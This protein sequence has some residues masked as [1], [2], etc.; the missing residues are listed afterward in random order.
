MRKSLNRQENK[1]AVAATGVRVDMYP[2]G[3]MESRAAARAM[4]KQRMELSQDDEDALLIYGTACMLSGLATP[5]SRDIEG[6]E[7]YKRGDALSVIRNGPIVHSHLDAHLQR[8]TSA[9]I[10]FERVHHREPVPGDKL[11][12]EDYEHAALFGDVYMVKI[13]T[14]AWARQLP[15][16]QFPIKYDDEQRR[17]IFTSKGWQLDGIHDPRRTWRSIEDGVLSGTESPHPSYGA[18]SSPRVEEIVFVQ[19]VG[20]KHT[21]KQA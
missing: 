9:S 13:V 14:E 15:H 10:A 18:I 12:R 4:V 7:V 16:L 20:G 17:W 11:S 8:S 19:P 2:V 5:G 3:S 21:A 6:T 1:A